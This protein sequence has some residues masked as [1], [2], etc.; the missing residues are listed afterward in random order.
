MSLRQK[1]RIRIFKIWG[2]CKVMIEKIKE[3][4]LLDI[5][6][7][8]TRYGLLENGKIKY[9]KNCE[10]LLLDKLVLPAGIPIAAATVVPKAKK[11]FEG[12]NV[13]WVDHNAE[14]GIDLTLVDVSTLGAD[15]IANLAALAYTADLPAIIVDCG[16]AVT[17]EVLDSKRVFRGGQIAPGRFLMRKSLADYTAQ[18]P[19]LPIDNLKAETFGWNTFDAIRLGTDFGL[20]GAVKEFIREAKKELSV[21]DCKVFVTGGDAEILIENIEGLESVSLDFTLLGVAAVWK[22]NN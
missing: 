13:F 4:F 18:L 1:Q 12:K 21:D 15:R 16:T 6:N 7:T 2:C 3:L 8:Y 20:I 9:A 17:I 11:C 10:T 5:G 22:L 19:F 14:T